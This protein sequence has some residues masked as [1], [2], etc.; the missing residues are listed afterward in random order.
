MRHCYCGSTLMIPDWQELDDDHKRRSDRREAARARLAQ[1]LV[2][3]TGSVETQRE[4]EAAWVWVR[5]WDE[6]AVA[7]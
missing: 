7:V 5:R 3:L 6:A 4:I 1:A 2:C